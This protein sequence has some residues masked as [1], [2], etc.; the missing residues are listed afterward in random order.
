MADGQIERIGYGELASSEKLNNNFEVL[1]DEIEEAES[2]IT[3]NNDSLLSSISSVRSSLQ[4]EIDDVNSA[5]NNIFGQLY[6]VG[7]IYIT[8]SNSNT[9]PIA[10]L[11]PNSTWAKI[12]GSRVLQQAG[13]WNGITHNPGTNVD[14]GLPDISGSFKLTGNMNEGGAAFSGC[15]Y[16]TSDGTYKG[17]CQDDD[18]MTIPRVRFKASSSNPIYGNSNT[19]QPPAYC[20]NIWRR[21]A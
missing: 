21:T 13:T 15:F 11:I 3:A 7:S 14:A 1:Q 12:G 19:V 17:E 6:P 8:T 10:S 16:Q 20:V 2:Q 9:C 5:I 4:T 18:R